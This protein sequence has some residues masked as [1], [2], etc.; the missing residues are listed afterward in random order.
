MLPGGSVAD[1]AV[2]SDTENHSQQ[3]KVEGVQRVTETTAGAGLRLTPQRRAVLDALR[4]STDHPT[5]A[6]VLDRVRAVDPGIGAATVYRTLA[7]LVASGD[8][9]ELTLGSGASA[10]YDGNTSSHDHVVCDGCGRAV[11]IAPVAAAPVRRV[12][13][14]VEERTGFTLTGY[15]LRLHGRCPSCQ[16]PT[17]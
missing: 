6:E 3:L 1:R 7:L 15:D 13:T 14:A 16:S 11:D 5:A 4:A 17:T 10:R 8:A 12:T 2:A 9:V